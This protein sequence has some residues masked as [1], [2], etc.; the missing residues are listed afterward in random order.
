MN[1][2]KT[3]EAQPE[4]LLKLLESQVA[5]ARARRSE[6]ETSRGKAGMI[7]LF[8]IVGGAALALW[9][10]MMLLEQMRPERGAR[11]ENASAQDADVSR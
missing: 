2:E 6:R 9:V 5:E 8:L 3:Q 10:L 7:G 4:Q 11:R 1:P